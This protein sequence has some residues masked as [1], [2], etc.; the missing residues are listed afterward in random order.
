[1][2]LIRGYFRIESSRIIYYNFYL[3]NVIKNFSP[4]GFEPETHGVSFNSYKPMLYH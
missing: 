1:M 4:P 3:E 2:V